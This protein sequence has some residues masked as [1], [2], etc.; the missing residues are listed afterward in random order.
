[1]IKHPLRVLHTVESYHPAMGGM[2]EVVR[3][4]SERL[5]ALGHDVTVATSRSPQRDFTSLNGVRI[6]EFDVSGDP[7]RGYRGDIDGYRRFLLAGGFDVITN[8][9]AQ[10]WATDQML[11]LLDQ[12]SAGKVFVPT[13]FSGLYWRGFEEY[14]RAMPQYMK[15]YDMNV[16][17]SD[18]YRDIRFAREHG[19]TNTMLIPNGAGA[20]EFLP[21]VEIDIRRKFGIPEG[22]FLIIQVGS[23]TG[24]KGHGD[25]VS[26]FQKARIKDATLL[27]IA[28]NPGGGCYRRCRCR[29]AIFNGW[30]RLTGGSKAVLMHSLSREETVAAYQQADLFLFPSNIECSPIVLFECLASRTPF[31]TTDVGNAAE[32]VRWTGA[33]VV[34][35]TRQGRRGFSGGFSKARITESARLLERMYADASLREAMQTSGHQAWQERFTWEKI[36]SDYERLYG[37]VANRSDSKATH[38]T[39]AAMTAPIG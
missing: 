30:Q 37:E 13:G 23:H 14:F 7:V 18:E 5:V 17:L 34:M 38:P 28:N 9:A 33:G 6:A 11:P 19:V 22:H 26:I 25:A 4:L 31:L 29:E 20:D 39:A 2:Q 24:L 32:I 21:R 35:P 16:F 27:I 8:F 36:A 15:K 10:Q 3:Q 12:I 1:V